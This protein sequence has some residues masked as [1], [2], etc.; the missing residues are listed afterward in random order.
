MKKIR[1]LFCR[2]TV[3]GHDRGL[4][5]TM[6]RCKDAGMEVIYIHFFDVKEI[7]RAAVQEDVDV[8]GITTSMG[9]HFFILEELLA[10]LKK[11]DCNIPVIMGGVIPTV[12]VPRLKETG[13]KGVFGPGSSPDDAVKLISELS[14]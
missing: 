14:E 11:D 1:V 2:Y 13:A 10:L 12:D 3:D 7:A 9:Q 5:T 4:L 6:S 8:I